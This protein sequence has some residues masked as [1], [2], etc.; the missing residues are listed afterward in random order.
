[1]GIAGSER[2]LKTVRG[3]GPSAVWIVTTLQPWRSA[4]MFRGP[5]GAVVV[6]TYVPKHVGGIA[7]SNVRIC[8]SPKIKVS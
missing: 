5:P 1:M 2:P 4:E 3:D 7:A 6:A 8:T